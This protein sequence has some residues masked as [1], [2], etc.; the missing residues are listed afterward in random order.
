V[1]IA[2]AGVAI[3]NGCMRRRAGGSRWLQ[4]SAEVTGWL[5]RQGDP[6]GHLRGAGPVNTA[7]LGIREQML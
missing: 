5:R 4:A 2:L 7:K 3:E 6:D 1:V